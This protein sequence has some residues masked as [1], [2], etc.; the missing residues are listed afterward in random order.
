MDAVSPNERL[1]PMFIGEHVEYV[2]P[3]E[4][5]RLQDKA[6]TLGAIAIDLAHDSAEQT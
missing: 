1:I 3:P 4:Y 2:T 5:Y 6:R